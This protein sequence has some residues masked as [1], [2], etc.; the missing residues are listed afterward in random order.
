MKQDYSHLRCIGIDKSMSTALSNRGTLS[1]LFERDSP[2]SMTDILPITDILLSRN[3]I[4][5]TES[6][7]R[8]IWKI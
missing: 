8:E 3:T 7:F 6:N 5:I 1:Y 2:K 4:S